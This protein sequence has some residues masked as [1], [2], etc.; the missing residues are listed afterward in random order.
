MF[1]PSFFSMPDFNDLFDP[2]LFH[3]LNGTE[4]GEKHLGIRLVMTSFTSSLFSSAGLNSFLLSAKYR[5]A[6]CRFGRWA[7]ECSVVLEF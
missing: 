7:S 4:D 6:R 2:T 1:P 3:E 5:P